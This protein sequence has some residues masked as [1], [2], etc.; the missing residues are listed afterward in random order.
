MSQL[1]ACKT[2]NGI[3]L[4]ADAKAVDVDDNGNLIE[5]KVDRLHQLSDYAA[6]LNGGTAAGE[7]MCRA[8]KQFIGDEGLSRVDDI[9]Q[10]ALP[11]LATQYERYMR[12]ACELQPIDP[13]HQVTFILG[14]YADGRDQDQF[15]LYLL[16]TKRKLPLLDSDE[17]VSAFSVPR[18]I[19][20]EHRLH[21]LVKSGADLDAV[22]T[23]VRKSL[24][25]RAELDEEVSEPLSYACITRE[26]FSR[27]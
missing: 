16:W 15:H 24:E 11:F 1:I 23:E 13:V 7:G 8:L 4:G 14:G 21:Q 12:K 9:Y 17:I 19:K 3:V 22:M 18:L 10:A 20:V 26:G 27:I 25:I 5:L 2:R 6:I